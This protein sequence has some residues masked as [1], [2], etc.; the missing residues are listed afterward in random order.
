MLLV[1]SKLSDICRLE[2]YLKVI[3]DLENLPVERYGDVL[4]TLTEAVNNAIIHGNLLDEGKSVRISYKFVNN[5][6][7]I[8]VQDEGKGFDPEAIPDPTCS[9][10][11]EQ[12]G[13]RGVRIMEALSDSICF[14]NNGTCITL[15]FN[16]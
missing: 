5:L 11:I 16:F 6:L 3:F 4:I 2:D 7:T 1:Q 10:R 13:G 12:C 14:Q 9:E 8:I 15:G